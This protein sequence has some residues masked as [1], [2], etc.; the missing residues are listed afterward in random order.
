MRKIGSVHIV[1]FSGTGGTA[2][3]ATTLES[4]LTKR[5]VSVTMTELNTKSYVQR[6][7]D[8]LI[9]LFPV[10]ACNA[11]RPID[12]WIAKAPNGNGIMTAVISVSGGGEVS[13]N[14]AS[15]VAT[16]R[17]LRRKGYQVRYENAFAMPSNFVIPYEDILSA[18]VLRKT[19]EKC[20]QVADDI[21]RGK[22]RTMKVNG[23]D[24][25][26]S[27]IGV[28]E[29]SGSRLFGK[30]LKANDK[31]INCSWCAKHC[32]RENIKMRNGRPSFGSNCVICLRCVYGCPKNAIVPGIGKFIVL[33][34]GYNLK[35][36]DKRT[37][38]ITSFPPVSD[39]AKGYA[40]S[41]IKK[42]LEEDISK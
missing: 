31:C 1:F 40:L 14:T 8:Y 18:M 35:E 22:R 27:K 25:V 9:V 13:P 6:N 24:R 20:I 37:K 4:E 19:S 10:Y 5:Q 39:I 36:L 12:E 28:I 38:E 16:I 33:K 11:A 30:M 3:I 26:I 7:A 23:I 32:P 29:K 41:G 17:K 21:I 15:R 42:Y 2:R 34:K